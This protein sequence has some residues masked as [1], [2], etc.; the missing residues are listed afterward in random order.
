MCASDRLERR[1]RNVGGQRG[2]MDLLLDWSS[3]G[4]A[5]REPSP[6]AGRAGDSETIAASL[7]PA[8]NDL[9]TRCFADTEEATLQAAH[10]L[11]REALTRGLGLL[12][13]IE[14]HNRLLARRL[15]AQ[16]MSTDELTPRLEAAGRLLAECLTPFEMVHRGVR[17]TQTALRDSEDRYR[18]LFENANDAIFTT[19]LAGRITSINRAAEELSGY[20]RDEV[21]S[22][23][24]TKLLAPNSTRRGRRRRH[25]RFGLP[26]NHGRVVVDIVTRDRRRVPVEVSTRRIYDHGRL[27]GL[28]GI[29]R[30]ITDRRN[31]ER[32]LRYINKGLEEKAKRIAH[33]LHDE[34]GQLLASV[35][36]RVA[37]IGA[38]MAPKDRRRLD[39]LRVLLDQVDDQL[40]RLSHE[41]RPNVLD[42]LGL[43]P[44]C[45]RLA[46]GVAKRRALHV[47]VSGSTRGRLPAEVEIALYRVVQ[48][49]LNNVVRHA[50]AKT[51]TVRFER[52]GRR[53]RGHVQD[54]GRGFD[55]T[56]IAH[57]VAHRGLGLIGMSER[58]VAVGGRLE[59]S[60]RP[61]HGTS[62][63]FELS[64]E[65]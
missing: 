47:T 3:T 27:V 35:Y 44:A 9:L 19:D 30:D 64:L 25:L 7:E 23:K 55:T 32:A 18:E 4:A 53:V 57:R 24:L 38:D 37:E 33:G 39:S 56:R 59:I 58:L 34:A 6:S 8:Y 26:E 22:L 60:S 41:L 46:E 51:A 54:D 31:A 10:E 49:A 36:L 20:R 62:V 63:G 5:R 52:V 43:L 15:S 28:Q 50:H 14:I 40:R 1:A 2:V 16:P 42:E 48:E 17:G 61:G 13:V 11:G 12:D 21:L 65:D 29:A 45:Q